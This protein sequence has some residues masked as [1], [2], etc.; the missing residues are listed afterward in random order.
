MCELLGIS[1]ARTVD[2]SDLLRIFFSHA[3]KHPDG[4]GLA[5]FYGNSVSLEKEPVSALES[6]YLK[7]RL[8][9][10]IREDVLIAHIRKASVGN[11][12]YRNTHPFARR[13]ASGRLWTL[14]HNGTIFESP[15]LAPY[16]QIQKGSTDSERILYDLVDRIS[17]TPGALS[18]EE[19]FSVVEDVVRTITPN[20][21]VN[22]L[23]YDGEL[24]Y[25]H[26]NRKDSLHLLRWAEGVVISSKPLTQAD[27][28]P[29]P[30]NTLLAFRHGK[31]VFTGKNHGNEYIKVEAE[32]IP[33]PA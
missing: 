11:L 8:T 30:L 31:L 19:R 2:C 10:G 4:W 24:L 32:K 26:T 21:M 27:W 13:D 20:N 6:V 25:I 18:A 28:E 1:S 5:R 29:A 9:D 23:I 17:G 3:E 22:L 12:S 14:A 16:A 7:N 33:Q 15:E